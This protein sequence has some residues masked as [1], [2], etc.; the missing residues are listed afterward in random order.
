MLTRHIRTLSVLAGFSFTSFD[1]LSAQTVDRKSVPAPSAPAAA[2]PKANAQAS[3]PPNANNVWGHDYAQARQQAKALNRPV[4]L[5]FHATWCGPCQQME[6]TVLNTNDVVKEINSCCV[7]IKVDSDKYPNLVHQFG[8]NS[9]PCDVFVGPDGKVLK[10]NQGAVS[11]EEYKAL[12][13]NVART[14]PVMQSGV[15]MARN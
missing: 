12:I 1:D 11:A 9:L 8:V 14:R 3:R 4:L 10:V 15:K 6:R 7:A 13:S 5:H 2:Q